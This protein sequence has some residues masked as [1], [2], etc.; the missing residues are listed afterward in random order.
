MV[1]RDV[2]LDSSNHALLHV[3]LPSLEAGTSRFVAR[4]FCGYACDK[5]KLQL[6][7]CS[8]VVTDGEGIDAYRA[9]HHCSRYS[10]CFGDSYCG[11]F[12]FDAVALGFL[13]RPVN[14]DLDEI[15]RSLLQSAVWALIAALVSALL[16]FWLEVIAW[17][18][19][20]FADSCYAGK[21]KTVLFRPYSV[22]SGRFAFILFGGAGFGRFK[23]GSKWRAPASGYSGSL[24]PERCSSRVTRLDQPRRSCGTAINQP[25]S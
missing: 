12:T 10:Y 7:N 22:V 2:H 20:S 6:S 16:W 24:A 1:K 15:R 5:W 19:L 25:D 4:G 9:A 8:L 21:S 23:V 11:K 18:G 14:K 17:T 3:S 13:R